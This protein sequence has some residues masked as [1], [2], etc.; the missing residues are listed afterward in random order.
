MSQQILPLISMLAEL[1]YRCPLQC[2]YCSNPLE[3]MKANRECNSAQWI[4][5]FTEAADMGVLQVHLSGG[6]PTLRQDLPQLIDA[7]FSR[8]VYTNLITAGVG[9]ALKQ[10]PALVEA[11]LDHVQLSVQGTNSKS[12]ELIGN[13]K[14]AFEQKI[15]MAKKVRELQLPLTINAPIHR[16]NIDELDNY[17]KLALQLDAERLEI[18]NVQYSGWALL[19]RGALM[20]KRQDFEQQME[21][22]IVFGMPC[23]V[24]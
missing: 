21:K 6:E 10:L 8:G 5:L 12:T 13:F 20:P 9:G 4:A 14:G 7:L 2:P 23:A 11:G 17:I 19:N 18:A 1:T 15:T 3:L 22:L 16:Y 24:F